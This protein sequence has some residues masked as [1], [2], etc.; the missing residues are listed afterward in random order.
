MDVE[1]KVWMRALGVLVLLKY[2]PRLVR[3]DCFS[4][5]ITMDGFTPARWKTAKIHQNEDTH[6]LDQVGSS[7]WGPSLLV[8]YTR[9]Q[10]CTSP[11]SASSARSP[12]TTRKPCTLCIA[13][14]LTTSTVSE[15]GHFKF[16]EDQFIK[17]KS[18]RQTNL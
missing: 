8:G 4:H 9:S 16:V 15:D 13:A 14:G 6:Y 12:E 17:N 5:S 11:S 10:C 7:C 1:G 3:L 2:V 18:K